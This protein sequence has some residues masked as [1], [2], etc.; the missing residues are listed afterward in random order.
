MSDHGIARDQ[1]RAFIERIERLEEEKKTIADDIKEV[2]AEAKGSGFSIPIIN[3]I[4]KIRKMDRNDRA[5]REALL[6]MYLHALGMA[7]DPDGDDDGP[8]GYRPDEEIDAETGEITEPQ[9]SLMA[10]KAAAS[11]PPEVAA[12]IAEPADAAVTAGNDL[13]KPVAAEQ[14]QIIREGGA[15]RET[16]RDHSG[17]ASCPDTDSPETA[18]PSLGDG[19]TAIGTGSAVDGAVNGAVLLP[20]PQG[21]VDGTAHR[22]VVTAGETAPP[23]QSSDL[24]DGRLQAVPA[25]ALDES[26][27]SAAGVEAPA[28]P[29]TYPAPG[30]V[31]YE[32]CPP[33]PVRWHEYAD[34][35]P[36]TE[37][38]LNAAGI[39]R[40][41]VKIDNVILDGRSRYHA[42]RDAGIEYPVVQYNGDDPLAYVIHSNLE[43]RDMS[44][45]DKRAV[46]S[47]LAKLVPDRT[48]EIMVLFGLEMA[49]EMA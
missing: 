26:R 35:F 45:K 21:A 1:L 2:K 36:E 30:I 28:A 37:V 22:S 11:I 9:P 7:P 16:D 23:F 13:R 12:E 31:T 49:E 47:R 20:T 41:I 38:L 33:E 14:G 25:P 3:E 19:D 10:G 43:S 34:C 27:D 17:D 15:P 42:A 18:D 6:D 8:R 48:D 4:I 46:A 29:V 44:E 40:P 5:E 32:R 39:Q 24:H